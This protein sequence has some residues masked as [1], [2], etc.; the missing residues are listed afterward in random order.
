[1]KYKKGGTNRVVDCLSLPPI[2]ALTMVLDSCGHESSGWAQ[3]H[4]IDLDFATT[5]QVVSESTLVENF[6]L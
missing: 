4:V 3:L 1:M 5:Y 6:H 2:A